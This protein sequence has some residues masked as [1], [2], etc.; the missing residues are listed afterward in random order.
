V[1]PILRTYPYIRIWHAGCSTGEEV[2]SMAILLKEAGLYERARI[3]ATDYNDLVLN[4]A[5]EGVFPVESLRDYTA[6]YQQA[7]GVE[8]FGDYYTARYGF[9]RIAPALKENIV[10]ANHNLATDGVFGEMNMVVCRN[11]LIYFDKILQNRAIGLF[12]DSLCHR[13]FLCLGIKETVRADGHGAAFVPFD[14]VEKIFRK[15]S[16]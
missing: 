9:A 1:L 3:Y 4:K 5:R 10:F 16:S 6:N 2:Y 7:G 8:S 12:R 14:K 13:G 15:E 11:V